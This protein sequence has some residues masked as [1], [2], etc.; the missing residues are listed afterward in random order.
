MSDG[1]AVGQEFDGVTRSIMPS[2]DVVHLHLLRHGE[3]EGFTERRVRGHIDTPLS[4]RGCEQHRRLARWLARA[5]PRPD[6]IVGS[7]LS[8]CARLTDEVSRATGV[9]ARLEPRLR[10]QDMGAWEGSTW[11]ELS[12]RDGAAVT[13]WW[14]DY[15]D[16][17]PPGG[18]SL[19]HASE[20]LLSWWRGQVGGL[21]GQRVVLVTHI[22]MIR[23][24]LCAAL[25]VPLDQAL[26]FSPP[27]ASHTSLLLADSG[28][29]VT[30]LGERPWIEV[31]EPDERSVPMARSVVE[32]PS[33]E[34]PP[35][36]R[37][38]DPGRS[39]AVP[40]VALCGSAGT[41]KSTLGRRLAEALDVPF[42]DETVRDRIQAGLDLGALTAPQL[43]D[44]LAELW[45]EQLARQA[46]CPRGWV[47]DR[48][49]VDYAAFW[50]Q[51][52]LHHVPGMDEALTEDWFERVLPALD[53]C[54]AVVLLPWGVLPLVDDGVRS[55]NRWTQFQFQSLA[56]RLADRHVAGA[57]LVRVPPLVDL[58]QRV[59]HVL[60][61]LGRD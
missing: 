47:T 49:P 46:A 33:V 17:C 53:D 14:D 44:L 29:V 26:R 57:H 51:Y 15:A 11:S 36:G 39:P 37:V 48:S 4:P 25:D 43:A 42:L 30:A 50:I 3:V 32:P 6:L 22:G 9:D 35:A 38:P 58:D 34:L 28:A 16:A 13:A 20:R 59:L 60:E 5:V 41:G 12:R 45:D 27:A 40:R 54:S 18:E 24:F 31:G 61:A 21:A 10:E 1:Q 8:R 7:D 23:A 56:E 2:A 52:H 55:T 19:R